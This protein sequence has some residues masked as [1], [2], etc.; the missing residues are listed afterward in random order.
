[1]TPT[2]T[3]RPPAND[4][5]P[6]KV[7][8]PGVLLWTEW[9]DPLHVTVT[10]AAIALGVARK[11]LSALVNGRQ[12]VSPEMSIRLGWALNVPEDAWLRK[13]LEYDLEQVDRRTI[14]VAQLT[15][16]DIYLDVE[17]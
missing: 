17:F 13:Q 12:G 15:P 10:D 14:R 11:T 6:P 8:H 9:L 4:R 1:M 3:T 16:D 5:R 2:T 7:V